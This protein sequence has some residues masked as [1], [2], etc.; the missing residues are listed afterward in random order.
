[1]TLG[2]AAYQVDTVTLDYGVGYYHWQLKRAMIFWRY[3][4]DHVA[5]RSATAA[6]SNN[7]I[8]VEIAMIFCRYR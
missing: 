5:D 4:V 2:G 6:P 3:K 7:I 1:M 8:I